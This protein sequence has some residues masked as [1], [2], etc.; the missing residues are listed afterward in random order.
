MD[1]AAQSITNPGGVNPTANPAEPAAPTGPTTVISFTE[2]EFNFGKVKAGE[3]VEHE[4]TFKNTGKEPL[5]ISNAKGSCGCTV[6][7]WPKE[8]IAP[9]ASA[10]IRVNF[11]SKGKSGPQTK[12]VTI[13]ANTD[14]VQSI[15]YIKGEVLGDP[16]SAAPAGGTAP[17]SH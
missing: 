3:K 15:I 5:V 10:K 8:P 7:E 16:A 2:T 12:Q 11:D 6:P 9:G 14:P 1:A 4:Y 17:Q 13:T